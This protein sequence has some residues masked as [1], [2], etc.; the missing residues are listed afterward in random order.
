MICNK[1]KFIFI[2][3]TKTAGTSIRKAFAGKTGIPR[4]HSIRNLAEGFS[5]TSTLSEDQIK[6][7]FKFTIVR[8]PYDRI[9]SLFLWLRRQKS[10][11]I[12]KKIKFKEFVKNV[13]N[14]KYTEHNGI[15]YIPMIDWII[16]DSGDVCVDFI[17]RFE[18]LDK[19]F[20]IICEKIGVDIPDLEHCFRSRKRS[21]YWKYYDNETK[22]IVE[23]LYKKDFDFFNYHWKK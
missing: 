4:H 17:G 7:Y 18:N 20:P 12:T 8:N 3:I 16:N 22:S 1:R 2:D 23:E 13:S 5:F 6:N 14:G 21:E 15:R 11:I 19:D 10:Q 9:V